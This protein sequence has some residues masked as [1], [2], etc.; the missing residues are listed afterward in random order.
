MTRLSSAFGS[1]YTADSLRTKTFELGGHTFKVR[2]PLTKE[3]EAIQERIE[4][5]D[6]SDYK[7]RF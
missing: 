6:E 1:N 5:I 2:V 7:A 4:N 3:M